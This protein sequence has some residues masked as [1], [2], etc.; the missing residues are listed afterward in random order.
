MA[1]RKEPPVT[2]EFYHVFNRGVASQPTFLDSREYQRMLGIIPFYQLSKLPFKYSRFLT[3]PTE[4]KVLFWQHYNKTKS[5]L[6]E[7]I[8]LSLMPNHF[9]FLLKQIKDRGIQQFIGNVVNSYTKYFNTKRERAGPLFQGRFKATRVETNEQLLHL[10][11]YIHLQPYTAYIVK[12]HEE[13]ERY[14]YSSFPEYLRRIEKGICAK[15]PI[16]ENFKTI[17]NY[18]QFVFDNADYQRKLEEIK[19]LLFE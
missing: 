2:G 4:E 6:V 11:R 7:I 5:F 10:S 14:P 9:H 12:T 13:L 3:L 19:H 17:E 15:E 8:S 18:K 16:L 1:A